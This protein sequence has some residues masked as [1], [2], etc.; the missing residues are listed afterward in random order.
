MSMIKNEALTKKYFEDYFKENTK[1]FVTKD[2]LDKKL[3]NFVTKEYLDKKLDEKLSNYVTKD[4]LDQN[5]KKMLAEIKHYN[6]DLQTF[7]L[8]K[9]HG[10]G[11]YVKGIEERVVKLEERV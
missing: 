4:Y 11:D 1:N 7:F 9:I 6:K 2:Y 3:D 5:T 8:E 10:I